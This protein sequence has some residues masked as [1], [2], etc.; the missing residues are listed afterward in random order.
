M[1]KNNEKYCYLV[2]RKKDKKQFVTF[3][4]FK[5]AGNRPGYLFDFVS[6]SYEYAKESPFGLRSNISNGLRYDSKTYRVIR[7]VAA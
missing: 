5:V 6:D 4:N 7:Q 3:G 1:K 2:E